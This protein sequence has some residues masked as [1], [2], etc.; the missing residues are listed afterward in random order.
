MLYSYCSEYMLQCTVSFTI[1]YTVVEINLERNLQSISWDILN[2]HEVVINFD[3]S[4][5]AYK[6]FYN[7]FW[8]SSPMYC[9]RF[10]QVWKS[11]IDLRI[12]NSSTS[13][14]WSS[15]SAI[16]LKAS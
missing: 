11:V 12:W 1:I 6:L 4:L 14:H 8:A 2:S 7:L 9:L 16:Y 13:F 10:I 5:H 3:F 15:G